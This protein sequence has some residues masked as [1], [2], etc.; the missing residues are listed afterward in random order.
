MM[1]PVSVQSIIPEIYISLGEH[2][3]IIILQVRELFRQTMEEEE[4]MLF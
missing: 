4:M 2:H 3:H 1:D